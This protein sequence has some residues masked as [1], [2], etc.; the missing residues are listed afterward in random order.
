[1]A[2]ANGERPQRALPPLRSLAQR[3]DALQRANAV[4]V[5]RAQLKRDLKD[6]RCAIEVVLNNPPACAQTAKVADL[7][8]ALP[9]Y[10]PVKVN[11]VLAESAIAP[12]KTIGGLSP[13]QRD[14]LT[15]RL[16]R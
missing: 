3:Q 15:A 2:A 12:T 16:A 11:T 4:R 7:L 5:Q 10:G 1:M 6:G 13:R 14:E 9:K 8:L